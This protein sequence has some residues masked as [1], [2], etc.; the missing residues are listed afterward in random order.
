LFL[1][2]LEFS[3]LEL[4]RILELIDGH[5]FG[6]RRF[7]RRYPCFSCEEEK[8]DIARCDECQCELCGE[9]WKEFGKHKKIPHQKTTLQLTAKVESAFGTRDNKDDVA[10]FWFSVRD[11]PE[12]FFEE[13]TVY[14]DL[15]Q[16]SQS[17]ST[18]TPKPYPGLVS[19]VGH[20]GKDPYRYRITDLVSLNNDF[21]CR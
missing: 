21:R 18:A 4:C 13:G 5:R 17:S 10:M 19:F 15:L 12:F 7:K 16:I 3:V 9:C 8:D 1:R 11:R 14:K 20:T 6:R 2:S